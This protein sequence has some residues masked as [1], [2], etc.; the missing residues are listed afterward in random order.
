MDSKH[1]LSVEDFSVSFHTQS[2]EVQAV[3]NVSF[4]MAEKEIVAVVGES[5]SGKSVMTQSLLKLVPSPPAAYKGGSVIYKGRNI[6]GYKRRQMMGIKGAEISYVFQDPMTSL[7]PTMKAGKQI[8]ECIKRHTTIGTAR[9]KEQAIELFRIMG[10]PN[11]DRRFNQYPHEM[12]GGMRQRVSIAIAIACKPRLLIADEPTTALDVTIQSQI[13]AILK[14]LNRDFGMNILLITHNLGIVAGMADRVLVMY[15]G[16]IVESAEVHELFTSPLH[17]YT[18]ALLQSVPR[19]DNDSDKS[20]G[21][22]VGSPPNMIELPQG[23]SFA[24]RCKYCMKIC[25][26]TYPDIHSVDGHEA[27]CWLMH[28]R[29]AAVRHLVDGRVNIHG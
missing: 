4:T 7:N 8:V 19:L 14:D 23:C 1:I 29:G 10:I 13:L 20:L 22:I 5:G 15:G 27:A 3:R 11:P 24:P 28:E 26:K 2:G 6:S 12:S 18:R 17:P 25:R 16:R 9:A 21:F